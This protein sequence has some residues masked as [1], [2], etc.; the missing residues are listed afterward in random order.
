[1]WARKSAPATSATY[2][3]PHDGVASTKAAVASW[4]QTRSGNKI[5][6]SSNRSASDC[7]SHKK[8]L[9]LPSQQPMQRATQ[10]EKRLPTKAEVPAIQD[11]MAPPKASVFDFDAFDAMIYQQPGARQPPTGVRIPT[12]YPTTTSSVVGTSRRIFVHA[13]PAIHQVHNRSDAWYREKARQ[14][15]LRGGRK[16]WFGKVAARWRW[17]RVERLY[18]QKMASIP[19]CG[20]RRLIPQPWSFN[21]P[22]NFERVTRW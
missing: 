16:R 5:S 15:K 14:I 7:K 9:K 21:R 18:E 22:L 13:N 8:A 11:E 20:R 4:L 12:A 1:M 2:F 19:G 6:K 3:G 17:M 10:A